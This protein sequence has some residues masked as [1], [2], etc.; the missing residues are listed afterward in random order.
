M[1]EGVFFTFQ[2]KINE[3]QMEKVAKNYFLRSTNIQGMIHCAVNL[4]KQA[5]NVS[6]S[7]GPIG[8]IINMPQSSAY[9]TQW[10]KHNFE[11]EF[12]F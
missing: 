6:G 7:L 9:Q 3:N 1:V 5:D 12:K 10:D 2:K 11:F 4:S 8:L